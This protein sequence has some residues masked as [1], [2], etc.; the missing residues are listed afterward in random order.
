MGI[1]HPPLLRWFRLLKFTAKQRRKPNAG[2]PADSGKNIQGQIHWPILL[3]VSTTTF[4][5]SS[6]RSP[7]CFLTAVQRYDGKFGAGPHPKWTNPLSLFLRIIM[8][9]PMCVC[10]FWVEGKRYSP[11]RI[12]MNRVIRARPDFPL[13]PR[14]NATPL[15]PGRQITTFRNEFK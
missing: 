8:R 6:S 12:L 2:K 15:C 13:G 4:G 14:P 9:P 7:Y 11:R 1:V 5:L 10:V 3:R